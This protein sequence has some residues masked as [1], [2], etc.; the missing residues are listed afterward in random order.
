M[1]ICNTH[2]IVFERWLCVLP[3]CKALVLAVHS[4][5]TRND[6]NET[7]RVSRETRRLSRE[8]GRQVFHSKAYSRVSKR[9]SY[10]VAYRERVDQPESFGQIQFFLLHQ[11]PCRHWLSNVCQLCKETPFAVI[12]RLEPEQTIQLADCESQI[13][14]KHIQAVRKPR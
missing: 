3:Q 9:N 8:I 2:I 14:L 11:P 13:T 5:E 7:R 6:S 4:R 1:K 12:C 10:T